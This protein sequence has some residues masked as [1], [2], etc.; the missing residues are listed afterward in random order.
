MAFDLS[1]SLKVWP[2]KDGNTTDWFLTCE[3][4][5]LLSGAFEMSSKFVDVDIVEPSEYEPND[6][7]VSCKSFL[8]GAS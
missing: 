1:A 6:S 7:T 5:S 3:S 8:K 2:G 4:S